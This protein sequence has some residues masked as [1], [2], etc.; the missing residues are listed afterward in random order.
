MQPMV[1]STHA[2]RC[3]GLSAARQAL[4]GIILAT[5]GT[6]RPSCGGT[7]NPC[8]PYGSHAVLLGAGVPLGTRPEL[9]AAPFVHGPRRATAGLSDQIHA[10][11]TKG[12]V[13][14]CAVKPHRK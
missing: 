10:P 9:L 4:L 11:F 13:R 5:P 6:Q 7:F 12:C 14:K 3:C 1:R 2:T 8:L